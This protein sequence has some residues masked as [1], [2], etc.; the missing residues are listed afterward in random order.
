MLSRFSVKK[1][2]TIMVMVVVILALGVV[3]FTRMT[4]ELFPSMN[5]PYVMISTPYPGAT[6]EEVESDITEPLEEQMASLGNLKHIQSVSAENYS[7]IFLEF[8]NDANLDT[9]SVDIR[10]KID[11]ADAEF[12]ESAG[13]P[14]IFKINPDMVPVV[15]TA[16][17][18]DGKETAELST[19]INEEIKSELESVD[20]VASVSSS[21][22]IDSNI[23]ISLDPKKISKLNDDLQAKINGQV[24][25]AASKINSGISAAKSGQRKVATGKEKIRKA[26]KSLAKSKEPIN[27][28][29]T[30]I[31]NLTAARDQA[32]AAG[33]T[34]AAAALQ[35]QINQVKKQLSPYSP[36][37]KTLGVDVSGIDKNAQSAAQASM[38]FNEAMTNSANELS[39]SMSELTGT[40]AYLKSTV[41]Q[42]Q[43]T[44]GSLK[45]QAGQNKVDL[46]SVLTA[47]NISKI[48][49]AQNFE[50]PAGYVSDNG[51]DIIVTVGDKLN[52]VKEIEDLDLVNLGID[53]FDTI[54]LS[55]VAT[56][57]YLNNAEDI[58][59][60][61]DGKDGVLLSFNKQSDVPTAE[62]AGNIDKKLKELEKKY[63][64]LHF[65]NL[66]DQGEYIDLI[67]NAVLKNLL[68]G[69]L[70]AILILLIFLRDWKPTL[71]T[72]ISIPVSLVFAVVLM[73]FSGVSLNM[74]SLAGLAVGVGML[75]DNSIVVIENIYRLRNEG[76]SMAQAAVSG[77]SQVAGAITASTLTTICVF[78][79]IVFVQGITRDI[80]TDMALTIG[81][82]LVASLFIALTVVPAS[83][84]KLL[85]R[86]SEKA[87]MKQDSGF[88]KK[89]Q[90]A[91]GYALTHKA[92]SI[93]LAVVL[94]FGSGALVLTRGF[95]FMPAVASDQVSATLLMD[96]D[97]DKDD[98]IAI[99]DDIAAEVQKI[100]GVKTVGAMPASE[101]GTSVNMDLGGGVEWNVMSL[102]VVMD[103][104]KIENSKKVSKLIKKMGEEKGCE[105]SVSDETDMSSYMGASDVSIN[106]YGDDTDAIRT[107]ASKIESSLSDMKGLEEVSDINESADDE[108]VI[109]V[110]REKAMKKGLTVAQVYQAVS[111]ALSDEKTSTKMKYKGASRDV[112]ISTGDG[113]EHMER[114]KLEKMNI[115]YTDQTKGT[116]GTFKI[117]D[118]G[119]IEEDK[120][121]SQLNHL[122]QKLT[123]N[124]T[125]NIASGYN[126]TKT[127]DKIENR[128]DKLDLP[129]G[130]KVE[131]SGQ[132]ED[133]MDAMADLIKMMLLGLLLIYLIMAAQFQS[134]KSPFIV[135]FTVP[136]AFTGGLLALLMTGFTVSVVA[137][138]GFIVLMGIIVNNGIVLIDYMNRLRR[139]GVE[140]REAIIRAGSVRMR[141]VLM[142]AATTV[143]GLLPLAIGLGDGGEM[144]QP[145]AI[146]CIGGL[147]YATLTTLL[148]IPVVYD[149]VARKDPKVV[150]EEELTVVNV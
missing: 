130:V 133:I 67:I 128:I 109:N 62:A 6:P 119:S 22:M 45:S 142:T 12:P 44:L 88:I 96:E 36:Q 90:K 92:V 117:S 39:N 87:W 75:V 111:N 139:E 86:T 3:S 37:L 150:D 99:T 124:V 33:Q 23:H 60:K 131:Y 116:T 148:I 110:D 127:Q 40:D 55:D 46:K 138:I 66:S 97:S 80:F 79:P 81:Y 72:A 59:A 21:G 125:A 20:G 61:V 83:A 84:S 13:D 107:A 64:G 56:V 52:S 147:I 2:I 140:R 34:Q 16:V 121:L 43:T 149:I 28:A 25:A 126:I 8:N 143:L 57:S 48:V 98:N 141:P 129:E 10:D 106:V 104:D 91:A 5:L 35:T 71:I 85:K 137:M 93:L 145:V 103:E 120:T 94:L 95:D 144:M 30:T 18:Y 50:M 9:I 100:D 132:N 1:P 69:A 78:F 17:S 58:Y 76:F 102:Y 26:Q 53:G 105:V 47:D 74:I 136:L 68:I 15:M 108:L 51:K 14:T 19:F 89:Y 29:L 41:T 146:V 113:K 38:N 115:Q 134:L 49:S 24:D 7:V 32:K 63:D 114:S 11:L 4:P 118:I 73:Y 65:S 70:L 27:K 82:S 112:T 42:L 122:D 54:K 123:V 77:A 101:L 135:M 31:E